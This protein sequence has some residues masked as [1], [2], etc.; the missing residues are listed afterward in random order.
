MAIFDDFGPFKPVFWYPKFL[1]C[2]RT[3]S[4]YVILLSQTYRESAVELAVGKRKEA[5]KE[6]EEEE[7][8]ED[9]EKEEE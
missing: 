5:D 9:D 1:K 3:L 8:E 7:E 2:I 4:W 6:E